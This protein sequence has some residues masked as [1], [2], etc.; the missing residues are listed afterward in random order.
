MA[1]S[2][3][4]GELERAVEGRNNTG[5]PARGQ[6]QRG[7]GTIVI[8]LQLIPHK[9]C[10]PSRRHT[11]FS[12][13]AVSKAC[14]HIMDTCRELSLQIPTQT[15]CN[16]VI[17]LCTSGIQ[18]RRAG[19]R[20]GPELPRVQLVWRRT[21]WTRPSMWPTRAFTR[22]R[23]PTQ[24]LTAQLRLAAA[25]PFGGQHPEPAGRATGVAN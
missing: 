21:R 16:H 17:S 14:V 22:M 2:K 1:K 10:E 24:P 4:G 11:K 6:Q 3:R 15:W 18:G 20:D 8:V 7:D 9:L 13:Q 25:E 19:L 12:T 5:G 23:R